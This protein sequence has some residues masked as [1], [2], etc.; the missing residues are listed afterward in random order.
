[1]LSP[2][3]DEL[4]TSLAGL[5]GV[6]PKTA[7]RLA[8]HLIDK[9]AIG[10]TR[11]ADALIQAVEKIKKCSNCR[12][13]TEEALCRVCSDESRNSKL[14]CIVESPAD[15]LALEQ[16]GVFRGRYFIL[17]GRLSPIDGMGP[18]ILGIDQL[19]ELITR[20]AVDEVILATHPTV[21]GEATSYF[22]ANLL[23]PRAIKVTRIA[24]GVP[25]GGDLGYIDSGTLA[26]AL[27]G[28]QTVDA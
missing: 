19:L 12:N 23:K 13:L 7:Q 4:V 8:L 14:L 28:R 22:I 17:Y 16:S 5:P 26:Q 9:D 3:F 2:L 18:E 15:V 1:M 27:T 21:E 20:D 11:L 10:A 24:Q 6:G 25:I